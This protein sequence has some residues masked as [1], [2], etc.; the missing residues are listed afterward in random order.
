MGV[1]IASL[2]GILLGVTV[3]S[4]S[5]CATTAGDES[6]AKEQVAAATRAW[7]DAMGSHDQ[8]RVLALY[9]PE[10]VLWG[11]T[12]P[13]IRDNPVSLREYFNFLRTAP[14]Y[15]RGV[16]G[17]QR[18]RVYGDLAINSG[19]YTFIGP[20]LDA[21]GKP[22]SRPGRFSFVYRNRDGRWLIVDHHSSAVPAPKPAPK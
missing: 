15:Y 8:E 5:G 16:L 18:I 3:A 6:G 19:T 14:S 1:Q 2:A 13:T 12:S 21:A 9:D 4:L 11:T 17:E 22:I 10:A 20:A 7:I